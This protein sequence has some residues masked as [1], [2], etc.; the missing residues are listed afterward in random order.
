MDLLDEEWTR[1]NAEHRTVRYTDYCRIN[2][3]IGRTIDTVQDQLIGPEMPVMGLLDHVMGRLDEMLISRL[4]T[5]W[6][7][8]TW[9]HA[10]SLLN[11]TDAT[12]APAS[13]GSSRL[14]PCALRT[15]SAPF[16]RAALQGEHTTLVCGPLLQNVHPVYSPRGRARPQVWA[17]GYDSAASTTGACC[18]PVHSRQASVHTVEK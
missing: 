2:D 17:A 4:I 15:D 7:E 9:Q 11:A 14:M 1:L 6:R 12:T 8:S 10:V 18:M 13:P 16:R 3:I 5:S